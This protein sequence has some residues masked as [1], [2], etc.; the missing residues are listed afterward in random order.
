MTALVIG[1]SGLVG[2]ALLRRLGADA[3]GTYRTRP[4]PGLRALDASDRQGL[5]ALVTEVR[6]EIVYFPAAEPNVELCEEHPERSYQG[7]VIPA[8]GALEATVRGG[9]RFVFFSTDY[10]FDGRAGPYAEDDAVAPLQVYGRHKREIEERVLEAG[11]MVVRT[12]TV[13]GQE[14]PPAKNF[15]L[16]LVARLG[17]GERVTVPQD[18][19]ATPTWADDLA[20]CVAALG[21]ERGVW[22]VAGP[23]VLARD[24]F[25][26]VVA[27]VFG[28]DAPS[29]SSSRIRLTDGLSCS[30]TAS[31]RRAGCRR[32]V[33]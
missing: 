17:A 10:V 24:A 9:A 7:N 19:V 13:F 28:L 1:A 31:S 22:H 4:R 14:P 20:E 21:A 27:E 2:A 5:E 30:S 18:Q 23:D 12:T 15:V 25:A 11:Q 6:P 8:L 3:V 33:P 26:R 16:R 32:T 29:K